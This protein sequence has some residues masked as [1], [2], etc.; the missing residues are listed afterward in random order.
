[1]TTLFR[2]YEPPLIDL[3]IRRAPFIRQRL[4]LERK[5]RPSFRSMAAAS[6]DGL[7]EG[8]ADFYDKSSG[9]WEN[10]WGDHMHHGFYDADS[11]ATVSGHRAAQ[12]RMIEEALRFAGVS[13]NLSISSGGT[14][15]TWKSICESLQSLKKR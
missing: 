5:R 1:M 4:S 15:G 14:N 11:S 8:I 13:G 7:K 2:T 3:R 10:I 9:V 12:I 6:A